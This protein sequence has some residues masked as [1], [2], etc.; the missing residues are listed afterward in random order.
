M[1]K[2]MITGSS[3]GLGLL[4]GQLLLS[5]EHEVVL[6]AR[7]AG[8]AADALR[9]APL[10]KHILIADLADIAAVKNLAEEVNALGRFDA[11]IHNAGV[12]KGAE[13][14]RSA[15]GLPLLFAVNTLAPYLLTCLI[16]KPKRLVYMSSDLHLG[17]DAT[18]SDLMGGSLASTYSD[19]KLHD[20]MLCMA[21]ARHWPEV[22]AN[23][24]HPGW[25]PT[26]MGGAGAPDNLT[27]GYQTQAW[28]AVSKDARAKV[29]GK[30]FF[31]Q[32]EARFLPIAADV[33]VQERLLRVCEQ[34]SGVR[35]F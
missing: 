11:I 20:L 15:D 27:E 30:Y 12:F 18:L 9:A 35:F 23:A 19:T 4:A 29:S 25:V 7:N 14:A 8:R 2:I 31:H 1:A 32:R 21:V 26:K 17:G 5:Q 22:Y 24:V 33:T 6:H 28:L 34:V 13:T 10:A 3:D 16:K